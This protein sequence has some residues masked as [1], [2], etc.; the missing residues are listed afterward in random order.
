MQV[1]KLQII[2]EGKT[3]MRIK[4]FILFTVIVITVVCCNS[5]KKEKLLLNMD[6]EKIYNCSQFYITDNY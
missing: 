1:L 5:T 2:G 6:I 3:C 4:R